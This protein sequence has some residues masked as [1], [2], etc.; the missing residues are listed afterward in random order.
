M[1]QGCLLSPYLFVLCMEW[2]GHNIKTTQQSGI[3]NPLKLAKAGPSLSHLFFADDLLIFSRADMI[4]GLVIKGILDDFCNKINSRKT[5]MFFF[6]RGGRGHNFPNLR[7]FR[8]S[9]GLRFGDLSWGSSLSQK[10]HQCY[11]RVCS[12]QSQSQSM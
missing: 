5:N 4:H 3:W 2:L 11:H 6:V 1:K 8:I 7:L 9:L 12:R 10:G